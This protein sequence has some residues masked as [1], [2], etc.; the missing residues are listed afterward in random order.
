VRRCAPPAAALALGEDAGRR[1]V[2]QL[3]LDDERGDRQLV[4]ALHVRAPARAAAARRSLARP[5]G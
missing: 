1:I 3:E 5:S 4:L 2:T